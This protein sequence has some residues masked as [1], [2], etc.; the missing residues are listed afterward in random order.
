MTAACVT[1]AAL[2]GLIHVDFTGGPPSLYRV[3]FAFMVGV[4]LAALRLIAGTLPP[5][6]VAHATLNTITFLAAPYAD[7]PSQGLPDARPWLGAS[8]FVAGSAASAFVMRKLRRVD[9][10]RPAT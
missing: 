6:I 9:R 7:D 1:A 5:A 4:A 8:M 10:G 2:F 3:P